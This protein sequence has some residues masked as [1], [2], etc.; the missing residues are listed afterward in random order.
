MYQLCCKSGKQWEIFKTRPRHPTISPLR[1]LKW[2]NFN[3]VLLLNE[4]SFMRI[5]I[6]MFQQTQMWKRLTLTSQ[7][8]YHREWLERAL[9]YISMDYRRTAVGQKAVSVSALSCG[10]RSRWISEIQMPSLRSKVLCSNHMG[11]NVTNPNLSNKKI[12]L[13]QF[14]HNVKEFDLFESMLIKSW[15]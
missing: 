2:I 8:N 14:L 10:I 1:D 3:S 12:D 6:C 11:T 7:T 13:R 4:A 5:K 9:M 15:A